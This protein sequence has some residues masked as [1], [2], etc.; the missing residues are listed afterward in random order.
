MNLS[1]A[2]CAAFNIRIVR[3][4]SCISLYFLQAVLNTGSFHS[5][6]VSLASLKAS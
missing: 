6:S 1:T 5:S 2:I 3:L 4:D